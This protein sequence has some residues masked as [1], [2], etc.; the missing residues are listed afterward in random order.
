[1]STFNKEFYDDMM[2]A[3]EDTKYHNKQTTN[4]E[5]KLTWCYY[6]GVLSVR[7]HTSGCVQCHKAAVV[8]HW[9]TPTAR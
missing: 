8:Q 1:L 9:R 7:W 2:M 3:A 5:C 6:C 4:T